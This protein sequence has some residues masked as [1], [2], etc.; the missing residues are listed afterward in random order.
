MEVRNIRLDEHH[1][2]G[3][4]CLLAD[5]TYDRRSRG[6]PDHESIWI[7]IDEQH[8]DG[9]SLRAD[10]WI[11]AMLPVAAVHGES[12]IRVAAEG[13]P[14]L[15]EAAQ[16]ILT[17]WKG[18]YSGLHD[19]ITIECESVGEAQQPGTETALFFSGG[20]DSWFSL[21]HEDERGATVDSL[22]TVF[23]WDIPLSKPD[24]IANMIRSHKAI[25]SELGKNFLAV[26][27]NLRE[28]RFGEGR[29]GPL[30][31]GAA[32]AAIAHV[33]AGRLNRML[34]AATHSPAL[35]RPWGSHPDVDPLFSS[36]TLDLVHHG[37]DFDRIQKIRTIVEHQVALDH[38]HVCWKNWDETNCSTCEKCLRTML[39]L[40]LFDVLDRARTFE[41]DRVDLKQFDNVKATSPGAR[42]WL[43]EIQKLAQDADRPDVV[44]ALARCSRRGSVYAWLKDRVPDVIARPDNVLGRSL[45]AI[46]KRV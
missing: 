37:F 19:D 36:A 14:K 28:T 27:T 7:E 6:K 11:A 3:T 35:K 8:T 5:V 25:A 21:L 32:L 46:W 10:P 26:K 22:V 33:F 17:T 29:W 31:H 40:E 16:Q 13:S 9:L 24:S 2:N 18:W 4:V 34:I 30:M 43:G 20:V 15:I 42:H 38:L 23:G 41:C 45:R 12:S 1:N 39:A 44:E